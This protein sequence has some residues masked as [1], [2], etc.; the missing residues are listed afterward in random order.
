MLLF[1]IGMDLSLRSV[2]EVWRLVL[3]WPLPRTPTPT[4]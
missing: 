3:G 1:P 2:R 4:V